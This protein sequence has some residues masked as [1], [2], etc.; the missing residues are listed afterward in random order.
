MK[1][2]EELNRLLT[3]MYRDTRAGKLHWNLQVKTTEHNNPAEKPVEIEDG[4]AWTIDEC[5]AA[6]EC[7]YKG[8]DFCMITY[9]MIKTAGEK[10][11]TTNLIFLPPMGIRVFHLQTLLP[12]AIPASHILANQIHKLWEL[13]LMQY[14]AD[15]TSVHLDVIPGTLTIV[16]D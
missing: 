7:K 12:Y 5:Y 8:E 14:K 11:M 13:L 4:I 15:K 10:V 9:E 16:E 6:Y 1:K 3:E 2:P